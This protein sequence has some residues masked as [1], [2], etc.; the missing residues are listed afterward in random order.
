MNTSIR[1]RAGRIVGPVLTRCRQLGTDAVERAAQ[2]NRDMLDA[3]DNGTP[4]GTRW[5]RGLAAL[6]P[7]T[8]VAGFMGAGIVQGVLAANFTVSAQPLEVGIKH[9]DANGLA[10]VMA[11][12]DTRGTDGQVTSQPA[13]KVALG[14]ANAVDGLCI[15]VK[16][17]LLGQTVSLVIKAADTGPATGNNVEFVVTELNAGQTELSNVLIGRSADEVAMNGV[18]LGGQPG[19]F[20]LDASEGTA[21]LDNVTGTAIGASVL[22]ALKAPD[23]AAKIHRGE[24]KC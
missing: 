20:G 6:L 19:G 23:F 9:A 1:A 8:L 7:A 22:G 14:T 12:Q 5:S 16:Q 3:A 11:A 17:T 18:P 4:H 15:I 21:K 13:A 24:A 10:L 2:A